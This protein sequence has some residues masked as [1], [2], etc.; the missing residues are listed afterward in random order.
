MVDVQHQ[1]GAVTRTLRTEQSD[2]E[3]LSV[4]SL[5]Q[6]YPAALEDVWSAVTDLDRLPRWFA[7][8]TGEPRVGGRYQVEANAGG[9][10]L[11]CEPPAGGAARFRVTWEFGGAVSWLVVRLRTEGDGTL[12][13]LEHSA[14]VAEEPSEFWETYGPGATG[15]GWD[16]GLLG[17]ALHLGAT[18]GRLSPAEAEAW[19]GTEEGRSFYRAS[20]DAWAASDVDTGTP[21]ETAGRRADATF[22]FFTGTGDTTG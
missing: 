1:I 4:Q 8:V 14:L 15:V 18:N 17:L 11:E 5:R 10:V 9:E 13:E 19:A 2:G 20:A 16:G 12:L 3:A 22:A 6:T 7:P 21:A